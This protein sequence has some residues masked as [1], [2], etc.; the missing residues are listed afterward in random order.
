[1]RT[2]PIQTSFAGG[3]LARG[4]RGRFESEV[5]KHALEYCENWW[6]RDRGSLLMRPG[7]EDVDALPSDEVRLVRL[8]MRDQQDYLLVFS[9][10]AMRMYDVLTGQRAIITT[11]NLILNG[12]FDDASTWVVGPWGSGAEAWGTGDAVIQNGT[13]KLTTPKAPAGVKGGTYASERASQSVVFAAAEAEA[14]LRWRVLG[15]DGGDNYAPYD[16]LTL[17]TLVE[18]QHADSSWETLIDHEYDRKVGN[19]ERLEEARFAVAAG[20]TVWVRFYLYGAW[21]QGVDLAGGKPSACTCYVDDV[22]L[23][24]SNEDGYDVTTPWSSEA[25][26]QLSWAEETGSNRLVFFHSAT[27]PWVIWVDGNGL[28]QWNSVDLV[29]P[30]VELVDGNWPGCGAFHDG[31]LYMAGI[32]NDRNRVLGSRA[33]SVFNLSPRTDVDGNPTAVISSETTVTP[34]CAIDYKAATAGAIRWLKSG[35]VL[36]F[37]TDLGEHSA[38]AQG[39]AL[40]PADFHVRSESGFGSATIMAVHAGTHVLYVTPDK[41][42]IR[43]IYYQNETQGWESDEVSFLGEDVLSAGVKELHYCRRPALLVAVLE[44]GSLGMCSYK[45]GQKVAAWW[46]IVPAGGG[47]CKT[48]AVSEGPSGSVLWMAMS[49]DGMSRLERMPLSSFELSLDAQAI[50]Q[51]QADGSVHGLEHLEGRNVSVVVNGEL[52]PANTVPAVADGVLQLSAD[53][54]GASVTVGLPF[55]PRAVTLPPYQV[56]LGEAR[57]AKVGLLMLDSAAPVV[58][59]KR[60]QFD[61]D[62]ANQSG[63]VTERRTGRARTT[64]VGWD[65]QGRLTI[66]QDVPF[67]TEVLAIFGAGSASSQGEGA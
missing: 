65:S 6:A 61:R 24:G 44:D 4:L 59:G 30:P 22:S 17:H 2:Q 43:A 55:R 35:R 26:N 10:Q 19:G 67:R 25:M 41:K 50:R 46:R 29:N 11:Q 49:R 64:L 45:P 38:V 18:V 9:H 8:R 23:S 7:T 42:E 39:G 27:R 47:E 1:M 36:L 28:W 63:G 40:A 20:D 12:G 5:Y 54:D 31:R 32:P 15:I 58:N 56:V 52:L 21:P 3:E 13:L 60:L 33:G 66:E 62:P 16:E 14:V 34:D 53:L 37:G 57:F 48:V 51:V